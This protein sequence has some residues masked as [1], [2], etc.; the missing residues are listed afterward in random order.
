M[1]DVRVVQ[2]NERVAI[3]V[4]ELAFRF[5]TSG[6]PGGQHAN[7][8]ETRV[9]LLFNV[10]ES[11][12][13]DERTRAQLLQKLGH[14]L[15]KNGLLRVQVGESRSQR[16]NRETAVSRFQTL[17]AHAL[18]KRKK[19]RPT[20]PSRAAREKRLASKKQRSQLKRQRRRPPLE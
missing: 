20:K 13:L 9:T 16:Q 6:G 12:S 11:P 14:R 4:A 5:S 8:S 2:I 1:D 7:R 3:P 18:K 15:D 17:L 19:R 10:A